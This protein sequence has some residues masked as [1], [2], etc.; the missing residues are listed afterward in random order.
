MAIVMSRMNWSKKDKVG[1]YASPYYFIWGVNGMEEMMKFVGQVG[2]PIV[3]AGWL[4][5]KF[6]NKL[7]AAEVAMRS[8]GERLEM[9]LAQCVKCRE[10]RMNGNCEKKGED[11]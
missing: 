5:V 3:V 4:L 8:L 6:E 9:H 2:F 7:D 1:R 10:S 11:K